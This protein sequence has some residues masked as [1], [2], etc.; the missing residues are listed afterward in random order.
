MNRRGA[1]LALLAFGAASPLTRPAVSQGAGPA[2]PPAVTDSA[3][4]VRL[5]DR[6]TTLPHGA[7]RLDVLAFVSRVPGSAKSWT[8]IIGGGA[9]VTNSLE[10]GGQIVPVALAQGAASLTNPSAYGT[11][12]FSRGKVSFAPTLQ[13]VYPIADADPFF[14][15]LG[16]PMDVDIGTLGDLAV[17]P[18]MSV[19]LRANGAGTLLS[20]PAAFSRQVSNLISWQVSSGVGLSRFDPRFG[21]SRRRQALEFNDVSVPLSGSVVY[22]AARGIHRGPLVDVSLQAQWPQ[23]YGRTPTGSQWHANDWTIQIQTSWYRLR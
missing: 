22:T 15:D 14:L 10:V 3:Y 18:T 1:R 17:S 23:L 8:A 21:L 2:P 19:D 4:P 5:L 9:G 7:S 11:Y 6:P 13:V 12:S 16:V 20:L